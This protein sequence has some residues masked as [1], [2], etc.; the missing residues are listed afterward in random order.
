MRQFLTLIF[1]L[2]ISIAMSA[3][4]YIYS[5][6]NAYSNK[7][8]HS[9]DGKHLYQG[10]NTYSNKILYTWDGK[11]LYQ[12]PNAYSN[13]ILYTWDGNKDYTPTPG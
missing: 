5:G 4:T 13:K 8:T 7:I 9:W 2:T 6:P 3:S 12:G 11:H 10:A 1:S